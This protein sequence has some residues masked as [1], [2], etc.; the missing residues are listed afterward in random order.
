MGRKVHI[1]ALREFARRTPAFRAR[2]AEQLVGDRA[3][4]LLMLH[5]M[6][7]R[8]EIHRVTRG[9]YSSEGD[10]VVSVFAF[11]P[12]YLGLQEALS[13]RGLWEQETN[14]VVVTPSK[15]EPGE[16]EVMGGRVIVHRVKPA[17]FFG[18]DQVRHGSYSVP[19]SDLEKTLIDLAYFGETPGA[20]VLRRLLRSADLEK[21]R[22]YL[23]RYPP[24]FAN[25]FWKKTRSPYPRRLQGGPS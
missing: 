12:A 19:A 14:V 15:V 13:V 1:D 18:F 4:A 23:G 7:K 20:D 11:S 25:A 9:W 22:A 6:A 8:G 5:Q 21:L 2:D 16:R 10:P 3:Y 17:Y 24:A